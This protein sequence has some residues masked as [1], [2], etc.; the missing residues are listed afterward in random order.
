M[1]DYKEII[2]K[3]KEA[4]EREEEARRLAKEASDKAP[5]VAR[6]LGAVPAEVPTNAGVKSQ[7]DDF[8]T[9]VMRPGAGFNTPADL[10]KLLTQ[11]GI[12]FGVGGKIGGAASMLPVAL[13]SDNL[14]PALSAGNLTEA[15]FGIADKGLTKF[16]PKPMQPGTLM[17]RLFNIGRG[18]AENYAN[19]ADYGADDEQKTIAA[20]GGA[21]LNAVIPPV[22]RGVQNKFRGI[23]SY[24][25]RG[26]N[27]DLQAKYPGGQ[28]MNQALDAANE[29][30]NR[31]A[32]YP[33]LQRNITENELAGEQNSLAKLLA[34][35]KVRVVKPTVKAAMTNTREAEAD[36]GA[37][38]RIW[39]PDRLAASQEAKT[40]ADKQLAESA[41]KG[42]LNAFQNAAT[43]AETQTL[44]LQ[45]TDKV[46]G[47]QLNE[48][49]AAANVDP[50][51]FS[52]QT[53]TFLNNLPGEKTTLTDATNLA[54]KDVHHA[55]GY[56]DLL[57]HMEPGAREAA[58]KNWVHG[59]FY[60]K[61]S[62][63][64]GKIIDRPYDGK[65]LMARLNEF[66]ENS[67]KAVSRFLGSDSALQ[68]LK[69]IA[70]RA[71]DADE[72]AKKRNFWSVGSIMHTG[73]AAG[74]LMVMGRNITNPGDIATVMGATLAGHFL[75]NLPKLAEEAVRT[76]KWPG[77]A[78]LAYLNAKDP[79]KLSPKI[80]NEAMKYITVA[81]VT[82]KKP[83]PKP[84]A[85]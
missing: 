5:P 54:L 62:G 22:L 36:L 18:G 59:L 81:E 40:L 56:L 35:R 32:G 72:F 39:Q 51:Q 15:A 24:V 49:K 80:L 79:A 71:V 2:E 75:V 69:E 30:I 55:E 44:E 12:G 20:G 31:V 60:S 34:D 48:M 74:S 65:R 66:D 6:A 50:A 61:R 85:K 13:N 42:R 46:L 43:S 38:G 58:Q 78:V 76:G 57:D 53:R 68:D 77:K 28:N 67:S 29:K 64:G 73:L 84:S 83:I 26:I 63:A 8:L 21:L 82:R 16:F 52:H 14:R 25:A 41:A 47:K 7:P 1:A 70:Q 11:F 27:D 4:E 10:V 33:A 23:P 19:A 45:A 9:N 37:R 17:E 3:E